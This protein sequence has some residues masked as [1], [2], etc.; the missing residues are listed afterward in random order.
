VWRLTM[1]VYLH[2]NGMNPVATVICPRDNSP[3][4]TK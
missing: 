2:N 4:A 1:G 3:E